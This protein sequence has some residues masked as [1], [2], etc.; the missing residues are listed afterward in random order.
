MKNSYEVRGDVTA[1]IINSPK[2]GSMEALISTD[3]LD[4]AQEFVG[5]W[6]ITWKGNAKS[7]YAQG[8]APWDG[9]KRESPLL[10]R[11]ITNAPKGMDVDHIN[12]DTLNNTDDN[13]RICTQTENQQN[14]KGANSDNKS[15]GIRGVSWHRSSGKW[16]CYMR[17]NGKLIYFGCY[18]ELA[19]AKRVSEEARAKYMPFS[20]EAG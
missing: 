2:H 1:I 16:Q 19:D 5:R 15:S 8:Y 6:C 3:K 17:V 4:R 9:G 18:D 14:R 12:H 10:H 20:V 7:F 11:W 13:I